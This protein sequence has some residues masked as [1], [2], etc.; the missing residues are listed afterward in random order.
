MVE[1]PAMDRAVAGVRGRIDLALNLSDN[2]VKFFV[3][4]K[5]LSQH[6]FQRSFDT[7]DKAFIK[8]SPPW[9]GRGDKLPGDVRQ[10]LC[11]F[12][13]RCCIIGVQMKRFSSSA[14]ETREC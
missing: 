5:T 4:N 1:S 13:E 14:G 3:R 2:C 12:F 10:M 7:L 8:P 9:S 6:F 11:G